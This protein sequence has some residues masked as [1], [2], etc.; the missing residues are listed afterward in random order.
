MQYWDSVKEELITV[1]TE[2]PLPIGGGGIGEDGK[3]AYEIAVEYGF[4]GDVEAWLESLRGPKGDPGQDA[5]P[6][7]TQEQVDAILALIEVDE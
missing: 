7:F 2:N 1:S 3:S 5:E 6:Q 4:V